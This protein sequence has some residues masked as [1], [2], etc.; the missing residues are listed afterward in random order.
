MNMGR[1]TRTVSRPLPTTLGNHGTPCLAQVGVGGIGGHG[2]HLQLCSVC[3]ASHCIRGSSLCGAETPATACLVLHWRISL[4]SLPEK[5]QPGVTM[6]VSSSAHPQEFRRLWAGSLLQS[7]ELGA[8]LILCKPCDPLLSVCTRRR[9]PQLEAPD[10]HCPF[11]LMS[12]DTTGLARE[13]R[14]RTLTE[15]VTYVCLALLA[16]WMVVT[17][18]PSPWS[19]RD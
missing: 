14:G 3:P 1:N 17:A 15:E 16:V 10:G 13:E 8:V 12:T 2:A 5:K 11:S 4:M 9:K 19:S 18:G 7:K 6:P